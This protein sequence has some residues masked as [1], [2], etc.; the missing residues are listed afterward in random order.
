MLI[1]EMLNG[2]GCTPFGRGGMIS[3]M[4]MYDNITDEDFEVEFLDE[5]SPEVVTLISQFLSHSPAHRLGAS[6]SISD[7]F[8]HAWFAAFDWKALQNRSMQTPF[9]PQVTGGFDMSYFEV[10]CVHSRS[11]TSKT[12]LTAD[13]IDVLLACSL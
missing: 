9:V 4:D 8:D 11:A 6:A 12:L 2:C 7:L 13:R 1:F 5:W 10:R 3:H